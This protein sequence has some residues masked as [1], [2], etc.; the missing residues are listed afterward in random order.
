M[1]TQLVSALKRGGVAV[2][3]TDTVYGIIAR[4]RDRRAVARLYALRRKTP[5]KP[6]IILVDS[7]ARLREFGIRLTAERRTFLGRVW[8][9]KVSVILPCKS[10]KFSYLHLGTK[11]LA[12]RLP[13]SRQLQ[14]L[15]KQTGPLV[16]PSANPEG[17]KP[18]ETIQEAK[19][20]FWDKVDIYMSAPKKSK[21]EPSTLVSLTG[22]RP[23]IIRRG[24]GTVKI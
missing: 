9:G 17:K 12:F 7:V 15:L 18:A 21:A 24:G 23:L 8:P 4:A 16:A 20:Y 1:R 11:S 10:K 5:E 14:T 19:R 6:F 2:I 13:K 22:T 3:P